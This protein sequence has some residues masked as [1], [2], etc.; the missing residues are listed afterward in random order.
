MRTVMRPRRYLARHWLVLLR[1]ALRYSA[2]R[3]AYVLRAVGTRMGPVVRLERRLAGRRTPRT[4]E[5]AERRA[6]VA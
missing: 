2:S 1:P 5:G 3:D 4:F 6:R